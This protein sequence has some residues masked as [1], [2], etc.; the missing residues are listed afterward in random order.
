MKTMISL[1]VVLWSSLLMAQEFKVQDGLCGSFDFYHKHPC[2]VIISDGIQQAGILLDAKIVTS[3]VS[4]VKDLIGRRVLVNLNDLL[5]LTLEEEESI[6]AS[7]NY[8]GVPYYSAT[9]KEFIYLD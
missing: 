3:R 9:A 7:F 4:N 2:M 1:L 5:M 6:R 8:P